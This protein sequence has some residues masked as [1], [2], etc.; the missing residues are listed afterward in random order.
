[1][2][3]GFQDHSLGLACFM[4]D[5]GC[6]IVLLSAA[7]K[8]GKSNTLFTYSGSELSESQILACRYCF[9]RNFQNSIVLEEKIKYLVT[10][11]MTVLSS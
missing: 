3:V 7:P 1:M 2:N 4:W 11:L 8:C 6:F 5:P 10:K 9:W